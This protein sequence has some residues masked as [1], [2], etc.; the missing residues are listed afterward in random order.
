MILKS[1]IFYGSPATNDE[2]MLL[3]IEGKWIEAILH[4]T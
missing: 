3:T 2:P 1:I 4:M